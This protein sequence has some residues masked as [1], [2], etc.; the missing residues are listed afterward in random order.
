MCGSFLILILT[1]FGEGLFAVPNI[2]KIIAIA[3]GNRQNIRNIMINNLKP[4][5]RANRKLNSVSSKKS[6]ITVEVIK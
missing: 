6:F 4:G 2:V 3:R 1:D 5:E